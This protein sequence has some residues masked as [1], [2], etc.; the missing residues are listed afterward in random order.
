MNLSNAIKRVLTALIAIPILL[1]VV[2]KGSYFFLAFVLIIGLGSF[3][4]WT[5]ITVKKNIKVHLYAGLL[6][7]A[8]LI[9]NSF[10]EYVGLAEV[11]FI[12]VLLHLLIELFRNSGS[13]L[14]N[15]GGSFLGIS[16]IS[17]FSVSLILIRNYFHNY[18]TGGYLIIAMLASIWLCD[19]AAYYIGTAFGR[20]RLFLRVSPKKSWEGAISGFIFSVIGM[21]AAKLVILDSFSYVEAIHIGVIVGIFGQIGDLV[22]S[23]FKRD[24][25]VKDSSSLIP[26]HGG[27][28]DRFDSLL[29]TSPVV[30]LYIKNF[31]FPF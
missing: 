10:F 2:Y 27:I 26:G 19:S 15:L 31:I 23:L 12:I 18:E 13:A 5:L 11:I 30:Y 29:F 1:F 3:Y 20:H 22:E 21:I 16:Y 9:L 17:F 4:E 24:A 8:L 14:F 28:L 6:S 25:G 7:T